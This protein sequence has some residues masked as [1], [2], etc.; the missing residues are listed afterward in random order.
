MMY[1]YRVDCW[2]PPKSGFDLA[3]FHKATKKIKTALKVLFGEGTNTDRALDAFNKGHEGMVL[4]SL[5]IES[6]KRFEDN[7]D[8]IKDGI[9]KRFPGAIIVSHQMLEAVPVKMK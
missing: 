9:E 5:V 6:D 3:D 4:E 8:E 2:I 7:L 1:R